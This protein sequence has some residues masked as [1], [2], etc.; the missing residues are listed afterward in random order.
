MLAR[1]ARLGQIGW[2]VWPN[3]ATLMLALDVLSGPR[4]WFGGST[5]RKGIIKAYCV[6]FV[7]LKPKGRKS[8]ILI[9][10]FNT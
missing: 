3:L 1:V 2:E 9:C 5:H 10:L 8:P 7:E 4:V 6:D